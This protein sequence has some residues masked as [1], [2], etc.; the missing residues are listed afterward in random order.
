ML[1]FL[2]ADEF[3]NTKAIAVECFGASEDIDE[4]YNKDIHDNRVAVLEDE[5]RII[6]MIHLKRV[7]AGFKKGSFPIWYICYVATKKAYQ[8]RGYMSQ[9][10]R[11]VIEVLKNE[12]ERF[13]FLV[14]VDPDIYKNLGFV[15]K[16]EF[17]PD[18]ADPLYADDGL[19]CCYGCS[20]NE[21]WT[22]TPLKI[23]A[24]CS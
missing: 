13:A 17:N 7:I 9:L 19:E 12:C 3:I 5:G 22:E 4:Y 18:E 1:R 8:H 23:S 2:R 16:W 24:A 21:D 6:S 20:L 14:P 15:F 10:M 11:F